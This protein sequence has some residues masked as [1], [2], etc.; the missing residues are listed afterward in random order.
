MGYNYKRVQEGQRI[1]QFVLS[2]YV[3][4]GLE[5]VFGE[6]WWETGVLRKLYDNQKRNLPL[7]GNWGTLVD[8]L[9]MAAC[10]L[11]FDLH[12]NDIFPGNCHVFIVHG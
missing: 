10:L 6:D 3:C 11:L 2:D 5:E 9:D 7:S 8:S 12:W 4:R 1:L